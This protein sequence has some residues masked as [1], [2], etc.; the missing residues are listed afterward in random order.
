[1]QP[2]PPSRFD[3]VIEHLAELDLKFPD[4]QPSDHG[5]TT[6]SSQ[7][8]SRSECPFALDLWWSRMSIG[9]TNKAK[10]HHLRVWKPLIGFIPFLPHYG[11]ILSADC[12][13]SS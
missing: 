7:C 5:G 11:V 10:P 8:T 12:A 13:E 2:F 9:E 6:S 1:M 4:S 3:R